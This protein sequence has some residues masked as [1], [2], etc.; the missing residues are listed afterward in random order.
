[1]RFKALA[2]AMLATVIGVPLVSP[3]TAQAATTGK[4]SAIEAKRVDSI[5]TP[6]LDWFE[7]YGAYQCASTRLPVDYDQPKGATT[8]VALLKVP[9]KDQ[10]HKIGT[11]FVNPGGPGGS[12]T[13]MA[14][15]MGMIAN[16]VVTSRFDIVGIDPRGVAFTD[17]VK[18]F[19]DLKAQT[20]ALAGLDIPFPID[21]GERAAYLKGAQKLA[22]GCSTTGK[23]L[24]STASTAE[25]ARDMD[26]LRRAVGDKKLNYLGFSY[27]TQLGQVYANMFPDRIRALAIDGTID[28]VAW[29][30]TQ[31]TK[32]VPVTLRL[33]S[34]EGAWGALKEGMKRCDAAGK[35]YCAISGNAMGRWSK[36]AR[37]LVQHPLVS[38]DLFTG[39]QLSYRYATF[40]SNTLGMLYSTDG[41]D[42]VAAETAALEEALW[43]TT[44]AEGTTALKKLRALHTEFRKTHTATAASRFTSSAFSYSNDIEAYAS[45]MCT[46]SLNPGSALAWK[47]AVARGV[48]TGG[49]FAQAWGWSSPW[50]ASND[51]KAID[52]DAYRGP[53]NKKTSATILVVGSLWD[54]AT[55]YAS[56]KAAAGRLGNARL[57][58]SN[59]WGHTA[60]GT[61]QCST[62][63]IEAYLVYGKLP[64][65]GATCRDGYQPFSI[66]L[67]DS[68][69]PADDV[70]L[71][72]AQRAGVRMAP[73]PGVRLK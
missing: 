55:S 15:M 6:K 67:S 40:I 47:S 48:R 34:A 11:L 30:G 71:S 24:S 9:S 35:E 36:V 27:G 25:V 22:Q 4:T 59:N 72:V 19:A 37:E 44:P 8:E 58:T 18:C 70:L 10:L 50:C 23:T 21:D 32:N 46:D 12:G 54:P 62:D 43:P 29:A 20:R 61:G 53:W 52:E 60:Y 56:A 45:V 63:A 42:W 17:Q 57:L 2:A 39:Q 28:P 51:W 65:A 41:M 68:D 73:K 13:Q 66:K 69:D 5:P 7:C 16:P 38:T 26:V 3:S 1:M 33:G 49:P 14:A 64:A 31:A